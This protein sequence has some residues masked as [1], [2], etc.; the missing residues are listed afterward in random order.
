MEDDRF[1]EFTKSGFEFQPQEADQKLKSLLHVEPEFTVD[2]ASVIL[3]HDGQ[4]LRLP[5]GPAEFD[6]PFAGGWPRVSRE[7]ESERHLA[8]IH[9]TF[10]EVPL[11]TNGAPPAWKPDA[12]GFKPRQA[13]HRL[14]LVETDCWSS[15]ACAPIRP[16]TD[17]SSPIA[18]MTWRYGSAASTIS[19]NWENRLVGAVRGKTAMHEPGSLQPP[20]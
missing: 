4:T 17:T 16:S 13:N 6:Q 10:Y 12:T 7:V 1:F 19:G 5:K 2:D 18:L 11:I 8:N 15:L 3:K 9:G 14:L 20:T